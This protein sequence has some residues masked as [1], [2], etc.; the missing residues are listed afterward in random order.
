MLTVQEAFHILQQEDITHSIQMVRRWLREGKIKGIS[1]PNRKEGWHIPKYALNVFIESR[2]THIGLKQ[3]ITRLAADIERLTQENETLKQQLHSMT[4]PHVTQSNIMESNVKELTPQ[5]VECLWLKSAKTR[6]DSTEQLKQVHRHL[7]QHLFRDNTSMTHLYNP[8]YKKQPYLC[9]FTNKKF[10]SA[11]SLI[12]AAI[13]WLINFFILELQRKQDKE[14]QQ[15]FKEKGE[16]LV[17]E[18]KEEGKLR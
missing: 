1:T 12:Q 8:K 17:Q 7:F 5:Q 10:S 13:P 15:R 11:E 14:E 3:T 9:P 16:R 2:E 18:L 6:E 4:L